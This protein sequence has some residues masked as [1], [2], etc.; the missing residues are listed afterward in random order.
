MH[1]ITAHLTDFL[2]NF[3]EVFHTDWEYTK[4]NLGIEEASEKMTKEAEKF[5]SELNLETIYVIADDG[6]FLQPKLTKDELEIAN[7][8]FRDLLLK[9]YKEVKENTIAI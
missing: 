1:R 8:G 7:W 2:N 9:Y 3:E 5:K 6:T 4:W